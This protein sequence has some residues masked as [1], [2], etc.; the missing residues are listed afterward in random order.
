MYRF[1]CLDSVSFIYP[2]SYSY[3]QQIFSVF[4]VQGTANRVKKP[5]NTKENANSNG[6]YNLVSDNCMKKS[7]V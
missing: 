3:I 5:T 6:A 4:C 1:F 2:F 7:N